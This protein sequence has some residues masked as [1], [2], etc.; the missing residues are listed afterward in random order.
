MT[1]PT[2]TV[3]SALRPLALAAA[4]ALLGACGTTPPALDEVAMAEPPA[5]T[6]GPGDNIR[7][8][9]FGQQQLSGEF[10]VD[11][12][13]RVALPLIGEVRAAGASAREL[14]QRITKE[15][16]DGYVRDPRVSVEVLNFRPFYIIG[17]VNKPGQYPYAA[18]MTAVTAVALAGGYTYRARQDHVV[19]T[20]SIDGTKQD[21][22]ASPN[23]QVMPDDVIRV[24][25]RLF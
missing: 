20:R 21:R 24:P 11:G 22:S 5:Y 3:K 25:E 1:Q 12:S 6:L 23:T 13:G 4:L 2:A 10:S 16:A 7:I 18:G 19:I 14:E 8:I 15:L 17:E 9:V